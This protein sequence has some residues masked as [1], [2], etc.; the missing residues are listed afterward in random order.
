MKWLKI[1]VGQRSTF[2]HLLLHTIISV[3]ILLIQLKSL[4]NTSAFLNL[5]YG[6]AKQQKREE[7]KD[8]GIYQNLWPIPL[9][10]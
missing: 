2:M 5:N 9:Q 4:N 8:G 6:S 1:G 10:V 7:W 3:K